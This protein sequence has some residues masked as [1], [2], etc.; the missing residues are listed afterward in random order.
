MIMKAYE[1][2]CCVRVACVSRLVRA[3]RKHEALLAPTSASRQR[4]FLGFRKSHL[5]ADFRIFVVFVRVYCDFDTCL[6]M[7][8]RLL[9]ISALIFRAYIVLHLCFV[10]SPDSVKLKY[11][12]IK[13]EVRQL[14]QNC[15]LLY[16]YIACS[17]ILIYPLLLFRDMM[18]YK[19]RTSAFK[20]QSYQHLDFNMADDI[21]RV[22]Q[23]E[24][25][26]VSYLDWSTSASLHGP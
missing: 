23:Y 19:D 24:H 22:Q 21:A 14:K 13:F 11:R 7:Q 9:T 17:F 10:G 1:S 5:N 18:L 15:L 26:Q 25:R 20:F 2:P 12:L 16:W 8:P 4:L 3:A 6:V